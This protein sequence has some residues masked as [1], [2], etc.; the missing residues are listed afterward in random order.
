MTPSSPPGR[1]PSP[2]TCHPRR[3]KAPAT[4][5]AQASGVQAAW[6]SSC[7]WCG[8]A[9][10]PC[11]AAVRPCRTCGRHEF[12]QNTDLFAQEMTEKALMRQSF[13]RCVPMSLTWS[14]SFLEDFLGGPFALGPTV[15]SLRL[16]AVVVFGLCAAILQGH[17]KAFAPG[18]RN[19]EGYL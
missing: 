16:L 13:T 11:R 8:R 7:P 3:T 1:R 19:R 17:S 4:G 6:I 9:V 14:L 12:A 2:P 15:S 10:R 18:R 5:A